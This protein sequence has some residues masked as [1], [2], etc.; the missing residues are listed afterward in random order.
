MI[1]ILEKKWTFRKEVF[2]VRNETIVPPERGYR[3]ET[4]EVSTVKEERNDKLKRR[5]FQS[6]HVWISEM[7]G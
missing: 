2:S 7:N 1:L 3:S 6:S 4:Y 5:V